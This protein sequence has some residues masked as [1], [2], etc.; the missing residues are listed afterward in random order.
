MI[1]RY[2]RETMRTSSTMKN[3]GLSAATAAASSRMKARKRGSSGQ[4]MRGS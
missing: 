4:K 2:S 1:E 3:A